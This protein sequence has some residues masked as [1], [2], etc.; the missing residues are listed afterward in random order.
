MESIRMISKEGCCFVQGLISLK[1]HKDLVK[2][3]TELG[4][5]KAETLRQAIEHF[6]RNGK[7]KGVPQNGG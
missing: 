3:S 7:G 5:S 4:Q 6:L 2:I 1:M